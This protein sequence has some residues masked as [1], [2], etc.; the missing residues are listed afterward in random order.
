ML[1]E[2]FTK[3]SDWRKYIEIKE[4]LAIKIKE[5]VE[6]ENAGFAFPSQSIYLETFPNDKSE[7]FNPKK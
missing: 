2:C 5:I 6:E 7:I 4:Q 3:S 1:V